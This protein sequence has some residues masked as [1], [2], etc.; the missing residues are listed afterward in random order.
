MLLW[1]LSLFLSAS[2]SL[3]AEHRRSLAINSKRGFGC[4]PGT[5][6]YVRRLQ[7]IAFE[8]CGWR[9]DVCDAAVA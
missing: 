8:D 1:L 2:F 9:A 3:G 5:V 4:E 6:H 7:E